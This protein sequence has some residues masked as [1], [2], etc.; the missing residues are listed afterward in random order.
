MA[1]RGTRGRAWLNLALLVL[2]A[3]LVAVAYRT[4]RDKEQEEARPL[5]GLEAQQ[6]ARIRVE[7]ADGKAV[8]LARQEGTWRVVEPIAIAASE[9]RVNELLAL[10]QAHSESSYAA[11]QADLG[12]LGLQ[13]PRVVIAYGD[14]RVAIGERNPVDQRRYVQVGERVHLVS[15][16]RYNLANADLGSYVARSLLPSGAAIQRLALPGIT[17]T[18]GDGG[19]QLQPERQGVSADAIQGLVDAWQGASAL[20]VEAYEPDASSDRPRVEV[21]LQGGKTLIFTVLKHDRNLVL[22]R[23]DIGIRYHLPGGH[24]TRLLELGSKQRP[25][26]QDGQ[27]SEPGQRPSGKD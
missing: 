24:K 18:R 1:N 21:A 12:E 10:L 4:E 8:S 3:V 25:R 11:E 16:H 26:E 20:W 2:L 7:P 9:S 15:G 13:P 14:K 22:A 19:W 23:P 6:V 17:L 5:T 27:T